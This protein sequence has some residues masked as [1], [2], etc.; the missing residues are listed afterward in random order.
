M[1][2]RWGQWSRG[3]AGGRLGVAQRFLAG[4]GTPTGEGDT[5]KEKGYSPLPLNA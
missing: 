4:V 2:L 1:G 3:D 5:R